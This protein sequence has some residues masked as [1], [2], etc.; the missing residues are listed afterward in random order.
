[1]TSDTPAH[2]TSGNEAPSGDTG[3]GQHVAFDAFEAEGWEDAIETYERF[4]GPI[5]DLLIDPI[6]DTT[7]V[8]QGTRLLDMACGHGNLSASAVT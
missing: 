6:L 4:F 7:G 8:G 1:M 2:P 3:P 5:T